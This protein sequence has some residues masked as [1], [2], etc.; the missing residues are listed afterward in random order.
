MIVEGERISF[1]MCTMLSSIKKLFVVKIPS[2]EM[3]IRDSNK[4]VYLNYENIIQF[5]LIKR[6]HCQKSSGNI[7]QQTL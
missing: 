4:T 7:L 6:L 5:S 1:Y 3:C 2:R